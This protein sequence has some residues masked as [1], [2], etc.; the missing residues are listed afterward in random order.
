MIAMSILHGGPGP[1]FLAPSIVDYLFGRLSAVTPLVE[2]VP[3]M[4]TQNKIQK[5]G[6]HFLSCVH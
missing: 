4:L 1:T 2:D 3:D 6:N 5:V